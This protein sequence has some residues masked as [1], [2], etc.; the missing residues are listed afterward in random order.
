MFP[1]IEHSRL[2]TLARQALRLP[3]ILAVIPLGFAIA[4]ISQFGAIPVVVAQLFLY[5]FSESGIETSEMTALVSGSWMAATLISSFA[6]I[7]LFTWLWAR[8][9]EKRSFASLGFEA[10][11]VLF[12][13]LR[14]FVIGVVIFSGSVGLLAAFGFVELEQGDSSMQGMA[15][16]GGVLVVLLGWLVQGAAEELIARGWMMPVLGARYKPW[17][18]IIVSSLFFAVLHGLNPNLS[19][20]AMLNL[21][22]FGFFAAFYALREG[23]LWGICALHSAWNW[24]QGNIFGLQVS[25][26]DFGGGSLLN[27][28]STGPDWFTGGAFGPEGGLAVTIFLL[29]GVAVIFAWPFPETQISQESLQE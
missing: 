18:G 10:S 28:A 13:Y 8:F 27:L 4:F 25:G 11:G 26:S 29:I 20:I 5:G 23:S 9:Y 17:I 6:L 24:V 14:G 15:A 21:A 16:L 22:L 3:H 1:W 19:I 2:I 7:F 12:K